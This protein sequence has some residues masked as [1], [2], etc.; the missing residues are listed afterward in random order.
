M[1]PETHLSALIEDVVVQ[2]EAVVRDV[3]QLLVRQ[4]RPQVEVLQE[5]ARHGRRDVVVVV[6]RSFTVL[7]CVHNNPPPSADAIR[8]RPQSET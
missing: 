5:V 3:R 4:L 1:L 8:A 2:L 7:L 6:P